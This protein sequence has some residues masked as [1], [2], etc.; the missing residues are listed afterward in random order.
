[1][2]LFRLICIACLATFAGTVAYDPVYAGISYL[3]LWSTQS[4]INVKGK[5]VDQAGHS[6]EGI[7]VIE[8][9]TQNGMTTDHDGNYSLTCTTSEPYLIF[10]FHRLCQSDHSGKWTHS[11][12]CH[13]K[14]RR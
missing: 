5:I 12:K 2:C 8:R 13:P 7:A 14:G 10:F 6:L 11:H 1:M 3:G 4:E 9:G